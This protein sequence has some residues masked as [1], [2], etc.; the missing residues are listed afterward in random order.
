METHSNS[1]NLPKG[2]TEIAHFIDEL[3]E[4]VLDGKWPEER[5]LERID[6]FLEQIGSK[7]LSV[8]PCLQQLLIELEQNEAKSSLV[9]LLVGRCDA[10]KMLPN[11]MNACAL[12]QMTDKIRRRLL[13]VI[14]QYNEVDKIDE[15]IQHFSNQQRLAEDAL[16]SLLSYIGPMGE[17]NGNV[18]HHLAYQDMS[19]YRLLANDLV[20]HT[21]EQ[22]VW[23]LASLAELPDEKVMETAIKGLA[24]SQS[25][26][27]YELLESCFITS[28]AKDEMRKKALVKLAQAGISKA[29]PKQFVPHKCYVSWI[30]GNGN[31]I[32]LMS[33]RT[34]GRNRLGMVTFMLNE[35]CGIQDISSWAEISSFEMESVI[36]SLEAQVGLRQIDYERGFHLLA[37]AVWMLI[38]TKKLLP[39][40]FLAVRRALGTLKLVPKF[41]AVNERLLGMENARENMASLVAESGKLFDESPFCEWGMECAGAQ[42]FVQGRRSL[43]IGHKVRK[44]TVTQFIKTTMEP[45]REIWKRRLLLTADLLYTISP[46]GYRNQIDTCLA[47]SHAIEKS[48]PLYALPFMAKMAEHAIEKLR[49][50]ST[51]EQTDVTS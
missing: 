28:K 38:N 50:K 20:Y 41:Y 25:L 9:C 7:R 4:E 43:L 21:D 19:F 44:T 34:G 48:A 29:A 45:K 13:W 47:L 10:R 6:R 27:A 32:L 42:E 14:E 18:F 23:L 30:D 3:Y 33:Q 46:R 1:K 36:K 2:Y 26:L 17:E 51:P 5:L 12:P 37:D 31:R 8:W 49:E 39:P 11:V 24:E 35:E 16:R 15:V 22:S 40:A